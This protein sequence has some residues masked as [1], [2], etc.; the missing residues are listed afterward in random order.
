MIPLL[1]SVSSLS[2]DYD[3]WFCDIWGVMHNGETAFES[4]IKACETFRSAGG[5]IILI[6]NAPR[7]DYSVAEQLEEFGV[8]STCY[9]G[10]VSSGDV[11]QHLI[12]TF[13]G[14]QFYHL[15][16]KR[17]M[18]VIE[19]AGLTPVP[20]DKADVILLTGLFDDETE[21]PED[22]RGML[23]EAQKRQLPMI[24]ANPDLQV[25]RG[26]RLVYCAGILG[27]L[28]EELGGEVFYAGK[29]YLPIY[30]L[31]EKRLKELFPGQIYDKSRIL[32]IG[33]GLKTDMPGAFNAGFDALFVASGLHVGS[34]FDEASLS[35]LFAPFREKPVGALRQF[36]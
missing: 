1:D 5:R 7:P 15:G 13:E 3:V 16:P 23:E 36:S 33:D 27:K 8:P 28:Y 6:T 18:P 9:D 21:G 29:P 25:E 14:K 34:E 35:D 19:Q 2:K 30:E 22:Y 11:S 17:D 20:F 26:A 32:C 4:S 24:C 31:A 12:Q 10:I